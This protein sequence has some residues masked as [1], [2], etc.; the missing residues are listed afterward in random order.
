[1]KRFILLMELFILCQYVSAQSPDSLNYNS[2][3]FQN[4]FSS[5]QDKWEAFPVH[6]TRTTTNPDVNFGIRNINTAT[7]KYTGIANI[8]I[9]IYNMELNNGTLPIF[10]SYCA[11]GIRADDLT[12]VVGLGW[13]LSVGGKITRVVRGE[14]DNFD[15]LS[16]TM[17]ILQWTG[18]N[19]EK[20]H[21]KEWDTQADIY[22]FEL[23]NLSGS[24][25][26]DANKK[27]HPIPYQN[28]KIEFDDTNQKFR[29]YDEKGTCYYFN[30]ADFIMEYFPI[31]PDQE[32]KEVRKYRSSWYLDKI[33]FLNG[34]I[35]SF[36]YIEGKQIT[37][38]NNHCIAKLNYV[39]GDIKSQSMGEIDVAP[40]IQNTK[41]K[42]LSRITYKE[43]QIDFLYDIGGD[44]PNMKKLNTITTSVN[45]P[46]SNLITRTFKFLYGKFSGSKR[47]KLTGVQELCDSIAVKP[48]CN[49][50]YYE[51]EKTPIRNSWAIDHWGFYNGPTENASYFPNIPLVS[52]LDPKVVAPPYHSASREPNFEFTRLQSL[53][54]IL[55]PNGGYKE[56]EY[57][58][59]EWLNPQTRQIENGGGL[60]IRKITESDGS[61]SN[62]SIFTYSYEGGE[63]YDNSRNYILSHSKTIDTDKT[64]Y[65][66][67]LSS[68]NLSTSVDSFGASVVYSSVTEKLPNQSSIKYEYMP[69]SNYNDLP[70][71]LYVQNAYVAINTGVELHGRTP[72]T[73]LAWGRN[74]LRHKTTFNAWGTEIASE[75]FVYKADSTTM[76]RIPSYTTFFSYQKR[77]GLL[78]TDLY[79]GEYFSVSC[80]ML[81]ERKIIY[82][83]K[84]NP[85]SK[86]IFSYKSNHLLSMIS[87]IESDGTIT[88]KS[89]SFPQDYNI[90]D[91]I[92]VIGKLKHRN[93]I[94]P[95]EE[96]TT[97]NGKVIAAKGRSFRLNEAN[98]KA[99]VLDCEKS[100]TKA[101]PIDWTSFTSVQCTPSK[102][103]FNNHYKNDISYLEYNASGQ[104][105]CYQDENGVNHSFLYT[106]NTTRPFMTLHNARLSATSANNEVFFT[107]FE[108][109]TGPT[110]AQA[111]SGTKAL[112]TTP[113]SAYT[114]SQKLKAGEYTAMFWHD[115]NGPS[116]PMKRRT[117]PV[118]VASSSTFPSVIF[119]ISGY[120]DDLCIIPRN[121]TLS[122]C[123]YVPGWGN[124]LETDEQGRD[125]KTEY[126]GFG[127]PVKITDHNGIVVKQYEYK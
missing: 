45:K 19:Y 72:K 41:P 124:T 90:S 1:M 80:P 117:V 116:Q 32:T 70:G 81:L 103:I 38:K 122:T 89:Y 16:V 76:V 30:T 11:S 58:L 23:P 125:L 40:Q 49:F 105:L 102:I 74:L 87:I 50:E 4:V 126:N 44:Y 51:G 56:L 3:N 88:G 54:K 64:N 43:Q 12:T 92:S 57:D 25:V 78:Y 35:V 115:K 21:T 93:A 101:E 46:E 120:V 34:D 29:I 99:I 55:Y 111:R 71:R 2:I 96:I 83:G 8:K 127:L 14:P 39:L 26:F 52:E 121:A 6:T 17:D 104:V 82:K 20:W 53:K 107:D 84:Y 62:P 27:A 119:G 123:H 106:S 73:S 112:S 114:I 94:L 98:R 18:E 31:I 69:L 15:Q 65:I 5:T 118:T 13:R 48:I 63:L 7:D 47:L 36:N 68:R 66:F 79:L 109:L 33:E 42:Y 85:A 77:N 67:Y 108:H 22:Y 24:F 9:P 86:T 91:T 10:L 75:S 60:R 59:H 37:Y 100:L 110:Y 61:N 95:L 113:S 28:V 97:R